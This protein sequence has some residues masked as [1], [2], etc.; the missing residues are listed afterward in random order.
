MQLLARYVDTADAPGLLL[1]RQSTLSHHLKDCFPGQEL[2]CLPS[3]PY[4]P[5]LSVDP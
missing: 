2:T 1:N 5:M 3:T 4:M